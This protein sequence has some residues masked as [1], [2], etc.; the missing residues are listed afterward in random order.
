MIRVTCALLLQDGLVLAAQRS[1]AMNHPLKWEFPGGK[2][3][4]GEEE[5]ACIHREILEELEVEIEVIGKGPAVRYP[6]V[7]P[8]I[9]LIPF[10]ATIIRG[11]LH[12]VEHAALKWCSL[13]ELEE[14]DWAEA[15]LDILAWWKQNV[16]HYL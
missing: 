10:V 4:E 6:Q 1:A 14:L 7:N 8:R 3:D 15:D 16:H 11:K 12:A 9:E 2:I 5:L 13:Q